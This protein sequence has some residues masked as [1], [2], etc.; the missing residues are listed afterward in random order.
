MEA[1]DRH[2]AVTIFG[3]CA[4]YSK[5]VY[6]PSYDGD[7]TDLAD[8]TAATKKLATYV[9]LLITMVISSVAAVQSTLLFIYLL[10]IGDS[11]VGS[12]IHE[13]NVKSACKICEL[14][15]RIFFKA[16]TELN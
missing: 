7:R 5:Q 3:I 1:K 16:K 4:D 12:K 14:R 9:F 11:H 8:W 2:L 15:A 6:C 13:L 10:Y